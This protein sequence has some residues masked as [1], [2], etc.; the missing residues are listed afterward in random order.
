ML[1][2]LGR[3]RVKRER[4]ARWS[5]LSRARS[6]I[7]HGWSASLRAIDGPLP[8]WLA[9]GFLV[10]AIVVASPTVVVAQSTRPSAESIS[11]QQLHQALSLAENGDKQG[12]MTLTLELLEGN[13]K[14][15]PAIKLKGMLLEEAGQTS[16]AGAAYEEALK[17][18]PNDPDLLLK[19]G[20]YKLASGDQDQA[21]KL[22][23]HCTKILPGDGDAHYYLSQAYHLNG[24]DEF[25][26]AAIRQSLKAEPDNPWVWQK[27]GE[28]LCGTGDCQTG[29]GWLLKAQQAHAALPRLDFD[30][31]S[32]DYQLMDFSGAAQYATRALDSHP[33]DTKAIRLLAAADV[34]LARWQQAKTAYERVLGFDRNDVDALLGLG[35]C[36][37]ELRNY[38][39]AVERLQSVLKLDPTRLLAHFY[40]SRAYAALDR[41]EAS[42][43]EAAL[44]QLMMEQ[45]TFVRSLESEQRESSI[46]IRAQQLLEA[47]QEQSAIQVYQQHFKGTS[48]SAADAY[49]FAGKLYLF[50]GRTDDGVRC[51][52]HAL[53][54]LPNVRGAHTYEGILALKS[55]DLNKAEKE[56]QSEL[57]NDPSYQTAIAEMGEVRYHQQRWSE[58]AE[59]LAKSR[60]MTPELLYMLCDSYFH[61]GNVSDADLN[62]EAMAAYARNRPDLMR[63]LLELLV[64]NGQSDLAKRLSPNIAQ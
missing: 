57:A 50:M 48:A 51:L 41:P 10:V 18:A 53:K 47:H 49:V 13:P 60:T 1:P 52:H 16:E 15:A 7:L 20:I 63:G 54:L 32:T 17:L 40:L 4:S 58:A 27:Y 64:R 31:A 19:T 37:L 22:L 28:L 3:I 14:F 21:I 61:V 6:S 56:F 39:A 44:H 11:R 34:K 5:H 12:A 26:L 25:A 42:E 59:L 62:A 8:G 24:Q 29:L 46:K 33:D 45:L 30:I 2:R 43:H 55:G 38:S 35:Q 23:K 9:S 36:E